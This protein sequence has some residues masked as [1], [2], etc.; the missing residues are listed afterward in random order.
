VINDFS[1]IDFPRFFF[2]AV[3]CHVFFTKRSGNPRPRSRCGVAVPSTGL[4]GSSNTYAKSDSQAGLAF[5][6]TKF[7]LLVFEVPFFQHGFLNR[8]LVQKRA[9]AECRRPLRLPLSP[10]IFFLVESRSFRELE[11]RSVYK[12]T[13][14]GSC[15]PLSPRLFPCLSLC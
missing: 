3:A 12:I 7:L 4:R 10:V 13:S 11:K 5:H 1:D 15:S 9:G 2:L 6:P 8:L 14:F